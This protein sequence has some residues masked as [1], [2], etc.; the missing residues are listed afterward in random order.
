MSEDWVAFFV[1][2]VVG[3]FC[4]AFVSFCFIVPHYE[5]LSFNDAYKDGAKAAFNYE[6]SVVG[7]EYI[8]YTN[9]GEYLCRLSDD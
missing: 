6:L 1:G 3:F 7:S 8:V 2:I 9:S 4:M 5:R